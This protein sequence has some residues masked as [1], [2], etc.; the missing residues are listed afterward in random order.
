[1]CVYSMT[2]TESYRPLDMA[3]IHATHLELEACLTAVDKSGVP[4]NFKC[5][6]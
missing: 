6:I 5:L 4:V 1:M 2:K 3:S